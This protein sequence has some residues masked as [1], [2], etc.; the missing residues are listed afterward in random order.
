MVNN[1]LEMRTT[2]L[3][4]CLRHRIFITA[5]LHVLRDLIDAGVP[6]FVDEVY[7]PAQYC[8]TRQITTDPGN[9]GADHPDRPILLGAR[10]LHQHHDDSPITELCLP[11][12]KALCQFVWNL[13]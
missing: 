8:P 6:A 9:D 12:R 1:T 2:F 4:K 10:G 7:D 5:P 13:P 11:L 3:L